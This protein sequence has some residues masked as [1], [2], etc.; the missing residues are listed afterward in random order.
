MKFIGLIVVTFIAIGC[1]GY[2]IEKMSTRYSQNTDDARSPEVSQEKID[3]V[4]EILRDKPA[5]VE[6]L[7]MNN[8]NDA[9][10][11]RFAAA[12]SI[13]GQKM[14]SEEQGEAT[15]AVLDLIE[16]AESRNAFA[17]AQS[18]GKVQNLSKNN[19]FGLVDVDAVIDAVTDLVAAVVDADIAGIIDA[20]QDLIAA[21]VA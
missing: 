5:A 19:R 21:L 16:A 18:M 1:G 17:I 15:E 20:L 14:T 2:D 12:E 11:A 7:N 6:P 8:L 13:D 9:V 4:N 3:S 10:A